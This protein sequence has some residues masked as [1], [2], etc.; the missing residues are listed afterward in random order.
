M[1]AAPD[2]ERSALNSRL[3]QPPPLLLVRSGGP[4][5]PLSGRSAPARTFM[6]VDFPL[7]L[8]PTRPTRFTGGQVEPDPGAV[9]P[10]TQMHAKNHGSNPVVLVWAAGQTVKC[11][12]A[13][14][15]C[16]TEYTS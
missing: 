7:P 4:L 3:I 2:Q 8:G 13:S 9:P 5:R 10:Q 11:R 15:F 16:P 14:V 6:R 1:K 12:S